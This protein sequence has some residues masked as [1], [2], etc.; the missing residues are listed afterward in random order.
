MSSDQP[1]D[2]H[3]DQPGR[4]ERRTVGKFEVLEQIGRGAMGAVFRARQVPI[5]RIVALKILPPHL[6]RNKDYTA[7]FLREA[8]AAAH[9]N[10]PNIVQAIAAG[11]AG[12]YYYFAMEYVN[13]PTADEVVEN[14]GPLRERR[15]LEIVR[16]TARGLAHAHEH[17]IVHRD[18][19]PDNI[20]IAPDG[21]AKLADLGLAREAHNLDSR[22]TQSGVAV[23]TP[24]YISPEQAKATSELDGRTD[25]YSL[26][27]TLFHLV[28]GRPP[29]QGESSVETMYMHLHELPPDPR[30]VRPEISAGTAAIIRRAMAK[31]RADRYQSADEMVQD[32]ETLLRA[33][34]SG[35]KPPAVGDLAAGPVA[36]RRTVETPLPGEH[37]PRRKKKNRTGLIVGGAVAAA[38]AAAVIAAAILF[39]GGPERTEPEHE[40]AEQKQSNEPSDRTG[41]ELLGYVLKE[42]AQHPDDYRAGLARWDRAVEELAS[43]PVARAR[44]EDARADLE[45]RYRE[46]AEAALASVAETAEML[47]EQGNYDA[48]LA[49]YEKLPPQF[50][51][52]LSEGVAAARDQIR[53]DAEGH[54]RAAMAEAK[55]LSD[56]ARPDH[57]LQKL[58]AVDSV[59]YAPLDPERARLRAELVQ[60]ADEVEADAQKR[61]LAKARNAIDALLDRMETSG[62]EGKLAEAARLAREAEDDET[63]APA[64]DRLDAV[65]AVAAALDRAAAVRDTPLPDIFKP[66]L[67][68]FVTLRTRAGREIEGELKAARP[69]ALV[70][71]KK[72][73][74]MKQEKHRDYRVEYTDLAE[75][76]L[77]PFR[78]TWEPET[79]AEQM[80]AAILAV[81]A[82]DVDRLERAL[83]AAKNHPLAPRYTDRLAALKMDDTKYKARAREDAAKKAWTEVIGPYTTERT[84]SSAEADKLVGLLDAYVAE[85]GGTQF[86]ESKAK[87]VARLRDAAARFSAEAAWALVQRLADRAPFTEAEARAAWEALDNFE[88]HHGLS[89][90]AC[91]LREEIDGLRKKLDPHLPKVRFDSKL[92]LEVWRAVG[93]TRHRHR[94]GATPTADGKGLEI[95]DNP[96][97]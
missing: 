41:R 48:A 66:H 96:V 7:R 21:T 72:Y 61:A 79:G 16:D 84:L 39:P 43:D 20:L 67:G 18:V 52:L 56:D 93:R 29:Y 91:G 33:S 49:E 34:K 22:V 42:N 10:H 50:T 53:A 13:G 2:R 23:G 15:A 25:I 92:A 68:K 24:N 65:L 88:E 70:I 32:L 71:D 63:Y 30:E 51:D 85:H 36:A 4:Q 40:A 46:A 75:E 62:A 38:G 47:A 8:K 78:P 81:A 3:G 58:N 86:A 82:K 12:A 37:R 57:G 83:G 26:A 69:D 95:P 60:K 76:T 54:I 94:F 80:A 89:D 5:D 6:A 9:L 11:K 17:D 28:T 90:L 44:A 31:D 74:V 35:G 1:R 59:R 19:K 64:S 87:D 14:E 77:A 27:A 73:Y 45:E 55:R 97:W